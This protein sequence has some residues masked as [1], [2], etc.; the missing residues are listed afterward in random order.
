MFSKA[1]PFMRVVPVVFRKYV[2]SLRNVENDRLLVHV[3]TGRVNKMVINVNMLGYRQ[4]TE[5][6]QLVRFFSVVCL[7]QHLVWLF[8]LVW[9]FCVHVLRVASARCLF[10]T[11]FSLVFIGSI[12]TFFAI[13]IQQSFFFLF[14]T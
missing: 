4:T 12:A 13:E 2:F 8:Q 9:L 6:N 1:R 14:C 11:F 7:F 3:V 10:N 5:K